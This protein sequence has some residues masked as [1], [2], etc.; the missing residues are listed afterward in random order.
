M[1]KRIG[2]DLFDLLNSVAVED[3]FKLAATDV[4]DDADK[5]RGYSTH[6]YYIGK[7]MKAVVL[8][9]KPDNKN[10]CTHVTAFN[11]SDNM[12]LFVATKSNDNRYTFEDAN[13]NISRAHCVMLSS[14]LIKANSLL[15]A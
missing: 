14:K 13:T 9:V 6:L 15:Y 8:S 3:I 2:E 10:D 4:T 5:K 12:P 1:Q 11:M 7:D